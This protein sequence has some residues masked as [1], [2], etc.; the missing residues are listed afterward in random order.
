MWALIG[1]AGAVL[2]TRAELAGV[3]VPRERKLVKLII[4]RRAATGSD[5]TI[6]FQI[7]RYDGL[8]GGNVGE[9]TLPFPRHPGF[10]PGPAVLSGQTGY[11]IPDCRIRA[12]C[13]KRTSSALYF[14][15]TS[16][17]AQNWFPLLARCS[18]SGRIS[19]DI[20]S[21]WRAFPGQIHQDPGQAR[22]DE[23]WASSMLSCSDSLLSDGATI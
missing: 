21:V 6:R 13:V 19:T 3:L 18:R 7:V 14:V 17:V 20:P 16:F 11:A 10:D 15:I 12:R 2:K 1:G 22:G 4:R 8:I 23:R 5:N 9:R